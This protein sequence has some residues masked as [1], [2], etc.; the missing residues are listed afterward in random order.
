MHRGVK[1]LDK[2]FF[3][4]APPH[5]QLWGF[6]Y[7]GKRALDKVAQ[8]KYTSS[9]RS[10]FMKILIVSY[11]NCYNGLNLSGHTVDFYSGSKYSHSDKI[12]ELST[13]YDLVINNSPWIT[14]PSNGVGNTPASA[15]L[16]THKWETRL[17]A[18]ELGFLLPEVLEECDM[19]S[20]STNYTE[21]VF[22]KPKEG[23]QACT[24]KIDPS[25][26]NIAWHNGE[27]PPNIPGYV[28]RDLNHDIEGGCIFTMREG[29]YQI[30]KTQGY[31]S[32]GEEKRL[33]GSTDWKDDNGGV[34][35]LTSEQET[36]LLDACTAWLDYAAT[37]GGTYEGEICTGIKGTDI[38]WFE[39][40]S[41]RGTHGTLT[42]ASQDWLDSLTSDVTKASKI[43]WDFNF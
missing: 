16:E 23:F 6:S 11:D 20:V 24:Y 10:K 39:Q 29:S 41:R 37:L 2:N 26:D 35:S 17:K 12:A 13:E 22:L 31:T 27:F 30:V 19:D 4:G 40:N 3:A 21:T 18:Q 7:L 8:L 38:Y 32:K 42:G 36:L 34:G 15:R 33:A 9:N 43:S 14:T 28:E 5:V 25:R 1:R